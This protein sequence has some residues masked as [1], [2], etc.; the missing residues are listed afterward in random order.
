MFN[1]NHINYPSMIDIF[2]VHTNKI[3]KYD[4]IIKCIY[5][6]VFV[7][8]FCFYFYAKKCQDVTAN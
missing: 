8:L 5:P 7:L 3:C 6:K 2:V 4:P 1:I